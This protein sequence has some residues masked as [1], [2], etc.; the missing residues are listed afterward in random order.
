[1]DRNDKG[2]STGPLGGMHKGFDARSGRGRLL[3]EAGRGVRGS[4]GAA[5]SIRIVT[6]QDRGSG[7]CIIQIRI[8]SPDVQSWTY[9]LEAE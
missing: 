2:K 3:P 5:N 7:M 8:E 1:M 4:N 9:D 6:C